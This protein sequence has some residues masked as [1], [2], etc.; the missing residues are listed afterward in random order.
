[1]TADVSVL[2]VTY[3][4]RDHIEACLDTLRAKTSAVLEVIIVDNASSDATAEFIADRYP[5]VLLTASEE[6]LGFGK[7]VNLAASQATG[8]YLLLLNPDT[9]LRGAAVDALV[10]FAD[11]RPGHGLYGGRTVDRNGDV[12]PSSC[13]GLPTAWSLTCFG[14]GLTTLF[15][16]SAV[17]DPES[18]G[19]WD[20]DT[21]REVG[22][23]TGCLVLIER[24][25]WEHLGGFDE[26]YW[27]YGEDADLS[28]RAHLNGYRPII[29][30][31]A[32]IFHEVG[33]SS[34]N[35]YRNLEMVYR[36]KATLIRQHF[37]AWRRAHGLAMLQLGI[38]VRAA[39]YGAIK[40]AKRAAPGEDPY[41]QMWK[42]RK[43][44]S[45]GY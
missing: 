41:V 34:A 7:G 28:Y 38:A 12:D 25:A 13:W 30:P 44:W 15:K 24:G 27:M 5:D 3:N 37:T 8:R 10:E 4:S 31:E 20:R 36:G 26:R 19:D 32:E 16:R 40:T 11:R 23:V 21:V 6:N 9:E 39:G 2:I 42:A 29:C 43:D 1:M 35:R 45:R 14:F 17:F 33:A 22:I 18:L